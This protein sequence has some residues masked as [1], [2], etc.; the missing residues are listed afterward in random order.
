[1]FQEG[2]TCVGRGRKG[3]SAE[4][5][6]IWVIRSTLCL[7]L[8]TL[9]QDT[10]IF[11]NALILLHATTLESRCNETGMILCCLLYQAFHSSSTA[12][13]AATGGRHHTKNP[14]HP[15]PINVFLPSRWVYITRS[16]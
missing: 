10:E 11:S 4:V 12:A 2:Q 9:L 8:L 6:R 13:F 5:S 16:G 3:M 15:E 1:M 14:D 7:E